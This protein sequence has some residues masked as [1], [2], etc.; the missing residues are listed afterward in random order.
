MIVPLKFSAVA[1]G[2]LSYVTS[3]MLTVAGA[4]MNNLQSFLLFIHCTN[5]AERHSAGIGA[6]TTTAQSI[7]IRTNSWQQ[8]KKEEVAAALHKILNGFMHRSFRLRSLN[9]LISLLWG[10]ISSGNATQASGVGVAPSGPSNRE[11][12]PRWTCCT[13]TWRRGAARVKLRLTACCKFMFR[14][15]KAIRSQSASD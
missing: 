3:V 12:R 2:K 6:D 4:H 13:L 15:L 7:N 9:R 10:F 5:G 1:Q 14:F 8:E 11:R